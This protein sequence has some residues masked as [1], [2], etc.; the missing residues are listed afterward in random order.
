MR[1]CN[2]VSWGTL[3]LPRVLDEAPEARRAT[4]SQVWLPAEQEAAVLPRPQQV[5][6]RTGENAV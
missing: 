3:T 5:S 4:E 2:P 1:P 6:S